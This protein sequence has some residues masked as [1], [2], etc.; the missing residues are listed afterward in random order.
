MEKSLDEIELE[1]YKAIKEEP[2]EI[3]ECKCL[4]DSAMEKLVWKK[5][6][7]REEMI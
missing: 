4:F 3:Q 1:I 5:L 2:T 6:K 7:S